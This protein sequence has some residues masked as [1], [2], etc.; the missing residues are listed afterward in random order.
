LGAASIVVGILN[1]VLFQNPYDFI[2]SPSTYKWTWAM[3]FYG[4]LIGGVGFFLLLYFLWVRKKWGPCMEHLF[5]IAPACIAVAHAFGRIGCF[6]D[7]C[8]YGIESDAWYA[9]KFPD[10]PNK[11]LPTQLWE[12]IFLFFLF[13]VLLALALLK[14]GRFNF[15]IYMIAYGIW[16]FTIE[17]WR[18]DHRG[19]L[20]PGL[21]PSQFWSIILIA[22]GIA[23]LVIQ[24]L[25]KKQEPKT[26]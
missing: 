15:T 14:K 24:I 2:Q 7:G 17:F 16:R 6:L 12:A 22:G 18:G 19:S 25:R 5:S 1:A 4:G 21:S 13:G 20:I 26:E 3:T 23:F 8:C 9:L 10:L 11:V